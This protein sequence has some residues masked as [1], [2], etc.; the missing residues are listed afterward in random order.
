MQALRGCSHTLYSIVIALR[1]LC[2]L[3]S[4]LG[5]LALVGEAR[6]LVELVNVAVFVG[7]LLVCLLASRLSRV[8][9]LTG[10]SCGGLGMAVSFMRGNSVLVRGIHRIRGFRVPLFAPEDDERLQGSCG[11]YQLFPSR[12]PRAHCSGD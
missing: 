12:Q 7:L 10:V 8:P 9:V 2:A 5:T 1:Q 6:P 11:L 3:C 4:L